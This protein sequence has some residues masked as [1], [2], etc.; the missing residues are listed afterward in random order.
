MASHHPLGVPLR[1][2]ERASFSLVRPPRA[3]HVLA[4]VLV[5]GVV[6]TVAALVFAPWQQTAVGSGRVVA[7]TP[8]ERQQQ[9][10][11]PIEGRVERWWVREG[12]RVRKGELLVLLT[13]N[14]P[15]LLSRLEQEREALSQRVEA[16]KARAAAIEARMEQLTGSRSQAQAAA[17]AR[18]A[19]AADRTQAAERALEAAEAARGTAQ[20]NLERQRRLGEG[21]L[22]STRSVELAELEAVRGNTETERARVS[23]SAARS[24][25]AALRAELGRVSNDVS[26]SIED[27]RAARA[28]ALAEVASGQ[29]ELARVDVRL[30]R[31]RT[32]EVRA[33]MDATVLRLVGGL[34]GELLKAGDPLVMLVPD[35]ESRAVELWMEGNDVPL[36]SA[37]KHVRLQFEGWPAVQFSGWPSVAVGTFGGRVELIDS[38]DDGKGMFRILVVPDEADDPWP[39]SAYLR[40]GVR[41]NGWVFLNRVRLGYE[42]WR[43]FNG[44]PPSVEAPKQEGKK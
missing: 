9:V 18:V 17:Q 13:D 11:A 24:E 19:M 20:L 7:L 27:A 5:A 14:D 41:V 10:E 2:V 37:G 34:G 29:A 25:E 4:R 32:Q 40:Q 8:V 6:A 15:Q 30:A 42:L 26:A 31:Q 12:S 44:F 35:T 23:L 28:A 22:T 39:A 33:P 36:L 1:H 21:G 3:T 38:T 43:R 16:G